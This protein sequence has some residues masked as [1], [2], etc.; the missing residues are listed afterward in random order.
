MC[1][2]QEA[3]LIHKEIHRLKVKAVVYKTGTHKQAGAA[4]LLSDK[5][6]L[7]S[8]L[9]KRFKE[10][11]F[12][13]VNKT[14]QQEERTVINIHTLNHSVPNFIKQTLI[15]VKD[16]INKHTIIVGD[17]SILS[18]TDQLNRRINKKVVELN[19]ICEQIHNK[20]V[21]S[22]PPDNRIHILFSTTW[23]FLKNRP[24]TM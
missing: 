7:H 13:L 5:V 8:R 11:H 19:Q 17:L 24:H 12:K 10:R 2:I 9:I 22:V 16:H 1:C 4:I 23:Y 15:N 3:H 6:D 14:I 18:Q 20:F 21:Q